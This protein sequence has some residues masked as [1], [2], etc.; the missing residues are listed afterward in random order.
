MTLIASLAANDCLIQ[1]GDTRVVRRQFDGSYKLQDD[2][3]NKLTWFD[4][5]IV[6][7]YSGIAQLDGIRTDK[8]IASQLTPSLQKSWSLRQCPE[9]VEAVQD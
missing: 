2:V 5:R 4:G 8:W 9:C 3:S 1:V 7:G 6:F